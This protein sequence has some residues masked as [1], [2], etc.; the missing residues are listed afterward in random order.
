VALKAKKEDFK[1]AKAKWMES[2]KKAL[3]ED[4]LRMQILA[5]VTCERI[6]KWHQDNP[7]NFKSILATIQKAAASGD[8]EKLKKLS[9]TFS[10]SVLG[11]KPVRPCGARLLFAISFSEGSLSSSWWSRSQHPIL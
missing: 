11:R 9:K 6:S 8:S 5:A 1:I 4:C 2:E 7:D 3:E 10:S